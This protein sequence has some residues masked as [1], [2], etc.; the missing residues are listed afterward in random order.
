MLYSERSCDSEI[1]SM[2]EILSYNSIHCGKK[3][4]TNIIQ[5]IIVTHTIY[6]LI[7]V[8]LKKY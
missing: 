6:A 4:K 7:T 8:L 5:N 3:Q 1:I 2:N